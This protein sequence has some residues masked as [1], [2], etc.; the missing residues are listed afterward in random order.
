[1]FVEDVE[2]LKPMVFVKTSAC[3]VNS[4][5]GSCVSVVVL[6]VVILSVNVTP[7]VAEVELEGSSLPAVKSA[8]FWVVSKS[9]EPVDPISGWKLVISLFVVD[10]RVVEVSNV[11]DD[12]CSE[13]VISVNSVGITDGSVIFSMVGSTEGVVISSLCV[14]SCFVVDVLSPKTVC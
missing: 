1:M 13:L 14:V 5:V 2:S 9:I 12:P 7:G 3:E 11:V 8:G 10:V 4:T 6:I